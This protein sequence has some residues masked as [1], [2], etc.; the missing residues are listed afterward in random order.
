MRIIHRSLYTFSRATWIANW[1][2]GII[3]LLVDI[4]VISFILLFLSVVLQGWLSGDFPRGKYKAEK[5]NQKDLLDIAVLIS[6]VI[7]KVGMAVG[8]ISLMISGGGPAIVDGVYCV[9]SHGDILYDISQ[10]LYLYLSACEYML[11][12]CGLLVFT[13]YMFNRIRNIYL[14]QNQVPNCKAL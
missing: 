2:L 10:N 12:F 8:F 7:A 1:V 9:V 3:N 14:L 13:T 4:K 5:S 11:M 6:G